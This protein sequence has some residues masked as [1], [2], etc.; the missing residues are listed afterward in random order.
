MRVKNMQNYNQSYFDAKAN[1]RAG[2]TWLILM[3]IVTGFYAAKLG[4][5]EVG[6]G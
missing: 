5:G 2:T 6:L 1:K 3:L 4:S